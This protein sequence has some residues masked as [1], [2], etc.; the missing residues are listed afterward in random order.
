MFSRVFDIASQLLTRHSTFVPLGQVDER[1]AKSSSFSIQGRLSEFFR[2]MAASTFKNPYRLQ[3]VTFKLE[4]EEDQNT[5]RK[6]LIQLLWIMAYLIAE[7]HR[8][9][10]HTIDWDSAQCVTYSTNYFQRLTLE[11]WFINLEQT[12][13]NRCQPLP[14]PYKRLIHDIN[15]TNEPKPPRSNHLLCYY[16]HYY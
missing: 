12:R 14:A 1:T 8:L 2:I 3:T 9:T 10:K 13:L 16:H 15:I 6:L 5:R 11:I 4:G 7:H